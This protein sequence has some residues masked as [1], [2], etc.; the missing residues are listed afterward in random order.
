MTPYLVVRGASQFLSFMKEAFDAKELLKL[1][2]PDGEINHGEVKIGDSMVMFGNSSEKAPGFPAMLHL[3]V[4]DAD[5]LY[6]RALKA[7]AVSIREPEDR[8]FGDRV[9][10]IKDSWGNQWWIATHIK[11]LTPE[12]IARNTASQ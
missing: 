8:P 7:G 2:S 10:A 11:D 3:Y 4:E 12:E 9:S 1:A 6:N 5:S